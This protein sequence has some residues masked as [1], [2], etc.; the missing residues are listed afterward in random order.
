MK[1]PFT[2]FDLR[3]TICGSRRKETLTKP[4]GAFVPLR[5]AQLK[6]QS[7]KLKTYEFCAMRHAPR[8]AAFCHLSPVTCRLSAFTLLE[9]MIGIGIFFVGCFAILALVSQSLEGARLLQR[10]M[11]DSGAVASQIAQTNSLVEISGLQGNLSEFLGDSYRGYTYTYDI[12]EVQTN[13][14][15]QVDVMVQSDAPR[16]PIIS[17]MSFLLYRPLSPAG[18]MDGATVP[19]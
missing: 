11:V 9:V 16:Q 12:N 4:L 5:E 13:K 14:L 10:P 18:S 15:F 2:I 7:A 17:R 3:F 1:L 8:H 6:T 19:R